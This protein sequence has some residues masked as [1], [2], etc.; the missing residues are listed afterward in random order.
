MALFY[1]IV[2]SAVILKCRTSQITKADIEDNEN[3]LTGINLEVTGS[4]RS[5]TKIWRG[6]KKGEWDRR[7]WVKAACVHEGLNDED[8]K[9]IDASFDDFLSAPVTSGSNGEAADYEKGWFNKGHGFSRY[10]KIA[11]EKIEEGYNAETDEFGGIK[12]DLFVACRQSKYILRYANWYNRWLYGA[13]GKQLMYNNSKEDTSVVVH[14]K[15]K[16]NFYESIVKNH[17]H[18]GFIKVC[19]KNAC[20]GEKQ[21]CD[22]EDDI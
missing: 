12:F 14:N 11:Y 8:I 19:D 18:N 22:P 16:Y 17:P 21:E 9:Y 3:Y 6:L 13:P 5:A 4:I 7:A 20:K 10:I 2:C 1:T 15:Y